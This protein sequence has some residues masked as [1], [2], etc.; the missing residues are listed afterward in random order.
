[1][2]GLIGRIRALPGEAGNLAELLSG[3]G[4]MPGCLSYVAAR[5]DSDPDVVWVTEVWESKA[6]HSASLELRT[7]QDAIAAGRPLIGSFEARYETTPVG[8]LGLG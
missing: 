6:A 5:D 8:G 7:V 3:L 2:Y 1:M 4:A